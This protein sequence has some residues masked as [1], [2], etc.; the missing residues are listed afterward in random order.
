[1]TAIREIYP[2]GMPPINSSLTL[3]PKSNLA[4]S[5]AKLIP[6][7]EKAEE[8]TLG[9]PIDTFE[10]EKGWT[11]LSMGYEDEKGGKVEECPKSLGLK[12]GGLIA[13]RFIGEEWGVLWSS[14]A[15]EYPEDEGGEEEMID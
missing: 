3:D 11:E 5:K 12:D 13:F 10:P 7:P 1:L 9:V 15:E 2:D 8:I 6:I 4:S 14:Y